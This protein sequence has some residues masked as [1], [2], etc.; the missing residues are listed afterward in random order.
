MFLFA[1]GSPTPFRTQYL[2]RAEVPAT[3][4]RVDSPARVALGRITVA[5]YLDQFGIVIETDEREVRAARNHQWAEPL[6]DG[7]RLY[8]RDEMINAL[9]EDVAL[10][11]SDRSAI[12]YVVDVFVEQLHGTRAGQAVLVAS[13]RIELA[14][15]ARVVERRF[16]QS[17]A[18]DREGYAA[19]VDAEVALLRQLAEAIAADVRETGSNAATGS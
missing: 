2:L 9:G 16:A 19:L 3:T 7:L 10:N 17:K 6:A 8:L 1:C 5:P 4:V 13:F 14:K 15:S 18:L 12:D 11:A